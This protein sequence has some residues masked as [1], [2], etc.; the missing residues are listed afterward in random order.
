M[1][2]NIVRI[3]Y[4]VRTWH[5][6]GAPDDFGDREILY[7]TCRIT[8]KGDD[9]T[10]RFICG[11][12]NH[13][14]DDPMRSEDYAMMNEKPAQTNMF[15]SGEDLPLFSNSPVKVATESYKPRPIQQQTKLPLLE[16]KP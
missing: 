8:N 2:S 4:R 9:G 15:Q 11:N 3:L 12:C 13:D 7:D 5:E 14:F 10:A 1:E 16:Q 6:N